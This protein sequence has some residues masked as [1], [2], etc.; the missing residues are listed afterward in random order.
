MSNSI[1]VSVSALASVSVLSPF[2]VR[3]LPPFALT[4]LLP[5]PFPILIYRFRLHFYFHFRVFVLSLFFHSR[6]HLTLRL[7]FRFQIRSPPRHRFHFYLL[8]RFRFR[9]S[10]VLPLV[11]DHTKVPPRWYLGGVIV[12]MRHDTARGVVYK[13][14]PVIHRVVILRCF[15]ITWVVYSGGGVCNV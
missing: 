15:F 11:S 2:R 7:R 1:P 9:P 5:F 6:L 12:S 13:V 14:P 10:C 4:F 8:F 3:L